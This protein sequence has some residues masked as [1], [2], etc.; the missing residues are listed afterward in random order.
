MSRTNVQDPKDV[1]ASLFNKY[2]LH[3]HGEII[4]IL[5]GETQPLLSGAVVESQQ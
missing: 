4:Q 1:R 3:Y 5:I 2:L